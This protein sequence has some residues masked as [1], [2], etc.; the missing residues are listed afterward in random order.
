MPYVST[1][2]VKKVRTELRATFKNLYGKDF[3]ISV[4]REDAMQIRVCILN[5]PAFKKYDGQYYNIN[6]F[7][8][9][10]SFSGED[11]SI[12]E[13]IDATI[14]EDNGT[15]V[16]DADYGTVPKFYISICIGDWDK[17]FKYTGE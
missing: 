11:L 4:R 8:Y 14:N 10:N 3:K 1:D 13:V 17:P 16:H 9:K 12:L 6:Q 15:L 7:Y 5:A 2:Y